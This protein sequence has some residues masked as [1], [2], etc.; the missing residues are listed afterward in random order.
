[1]RLV[2]VEHLVETRAWYDDAISRSN[3]PYGES[4]HWTRPLDVLLVG[5][6][7][8]L[9]AF[10][11]WHRALWI[12]GVGISPALLAGAALVLVWG[13]RIHRM[14]NALLAVLLFMCQPALM[15]MCAAGR[16]DHHSLLIFA[17]TLTAVLTHRSLRLR[18]SPPTAFAAGLSVAFGLWVS[19]EFLPLT[20]W[21][22]LGVAVTG[23]LL[24]TSAM[25]KTRAMAWGLVLGLGLFLCLEHPPARWNHG[26]PDQLGLHHVM[27]SLAAAMAMEIALR[28]QRRRSFPVQGRLFLHGGAALAPAAIAVW[29]WPALFSD[30]FGYLPEELRSQWLDHVGDLQPLHHLA[31]PSAAALLI[32]L[33]PLPVIGLLAAGRALRRR[34]LT[35]LSPRTAGG[36]WWLGGGVLLALMAWT[37]FRWTA[38]AQIFLVPPLLLW[39]IRLRNA[40]G[41][42]RALRSAALGRV[43]VTLLLTCGYLLF[44]PFSTAF[45]PRHPA[46]TPAGPRV[47]PEGTP[48]PATLQEMAAWVLTQPG[49][50]NA[51]VLAPLDD[52]PEWLYR[53]QVRVIATPYHRNI[54]GILDSHA[55]MS[56]SP[57]DTAH[58][59]L[60]ERGVDFIVWRAQPGAD[61]FWT[62]GAS[63]GSL[64]SALRQGQI[65]AWLTPVELPP[66]LARRIH[67][68][69]INH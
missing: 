13:L 16:P 19:V 1:M 21:A 8:P 39:T 35:A 10:L 24:G 50:E 14:E 23:I 48:R 37:C 28:L 47:T 59:K 55:L 9:A 29:A 66:H 32:W 49:W 7:A 64:F 30:P 27:G 15:Q 4:L 45:T 6:A 65:P 20:A 41:R 17:A 31:A 3:A 58:A 60:R 34:S 22:C 54:R 51:V 67:A 57:S 56:Q 68:Y 44:T 46:P 69:K 2:R 62:A 18:E 53:T 5:G 52:G 11:G 33:F 63:D 26:L 38:Y 12:W 42:H 36:W 43:G 25:E 61:Q 40:A